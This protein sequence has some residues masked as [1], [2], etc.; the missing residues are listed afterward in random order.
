MSLNNFISRQFGKPSGLGG[1]LVSQIM[2]Q[3]NRPMYEE[4]L[5]L[6]SMRE[7][8]HVLDIGCGDG[9]A[10]NMLATQQKGHFAGVDISEHIIKSAQS[11]NR[12]YIR[13]GTMEFHC[14]DLSK[15]PFEK[16]AFDKAFTINTVYFW[17][18]LHTAFVEIRRV[19]K[20]DGIFI[21]TL[22]TNAALSRFS[23]TKSGYNRYE[24]DLL[25]KEANE[26]G[27]EA[28][29]IMILDG[30]AYCLVCKAI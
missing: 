2:H 9:Y 15:M 20:T 26:A 1:R 27:F 11:R 19:T 14:N 30:M 29:T 24:P 4:T 22:Y 13:S 28:S 17:S 25:I 12:R 8:E 18:D 21:N 5:R 16:A 10:L 3:Q 23:H 6:L 7:N